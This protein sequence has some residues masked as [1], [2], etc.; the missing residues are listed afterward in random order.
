MSF[1]NDFPDEFGGVEPD[2]LPRIY[3]TLDRWR[4]ALVAFAVLMTVIAV[5]VLSNSSEILMSL[6]IQVRCR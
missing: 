6:L 3:S 5:G 2:V 1:P 4:F